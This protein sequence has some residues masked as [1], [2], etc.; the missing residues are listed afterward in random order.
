MNLCTFEKPDRSGIIP[1]I[2]GQDTDG[3]YVERGGVVEKLIAGGTLDGCRTVGYAECGTDL[4][5]YTVDTSWKGTHHGDIPK[6]VK[7]VEYR[8][9]VMSE[10]F[11]RS[12]D[13]CSGAESKGNVSGNTNG[14]GDGEESR[15]DEENDEE[16]R[17]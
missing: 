4:T 12:R 2:V 15:I 17:L 5:G 8:E 10:Y 16:E 11:K 1:R 9:P 7:L 13:C 14:D 3:L 6:H